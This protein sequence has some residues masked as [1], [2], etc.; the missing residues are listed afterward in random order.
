MSEILAE[1]SGFEKIR[2]PNC[3]NVVGAFGVVCACTVPCP[4]CKQPIDVLS[5]N[6]ELIVRKRRGRG[7]EPTLQE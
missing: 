7:W 6:D 5:N 4:K 1:C 3:G 2:C